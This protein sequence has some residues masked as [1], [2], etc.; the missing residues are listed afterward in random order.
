[1]LNDVCHTILR[2]ST[3]YFHC[4]QETNKFE[5][6]KMRVLLPVTGNQLVAPIKRGKKNRNF[7]FRLIENVQQI[8]G[9]ATTINKQYDALT[10]KGEDDEKRVLFFSNGKMRADF[11]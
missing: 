3:F 10:R 8:V 1:M 4:D 11:G 2:F 6:H 9:Y 5:A 7:P